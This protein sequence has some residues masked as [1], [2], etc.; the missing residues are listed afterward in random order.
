VKNLLINILL[1]SL[2]FC[3]PKQRVIVLNYHQV[4]RE[5]APLLPN[6]PDAELF[7]KHLEWISEYFDID[8][9]SN[10][11]NKLDNNKLYRPIVALTFDDGYRSNYEVA[12]PI[13][14]RHDVKATF[15]I[16]SSVLDDGIMWND[17]ILYALQKTTLKEATIH[18]GDTRI[19]LD[20]SADSIDANVK[21]LIL[22]TK[23][24]PRDQ[25]NLLNKA[26][27]KS[28][29]ISDG[30]PTDLMMQRKQ[31]EAV[32]KWGIDI[33]AHALQHD[34]LTTLA[35]TVAEQEIQQ[36][37]DDLEDITKR[38]IRHFAYPNGKENI[39]FNSAHVY[40]VRA[41]GY[42]AAFTTSTGAISRKTDRYRLP[43]ILPW[44]KSKF[45][46]LVSMFGAI[47]K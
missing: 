2:Q 8:S 31:I 3:L 34:I 46:F 26:L 9:L 33:G 42:E 6:E 25:R 30:L 17:I 40:M 22:E 27:C 29:N 44:R 15:F 18:S 7:E 39:D 1:K 38:P 19:H 47:L 11:L 35:D 4:L 32:E 14:K 12:L 5:A 28:L 10:A 41:A 43:R 16:V 36:V 21:K 13:L 23:Y 45:G 37:K 20:L 24:L